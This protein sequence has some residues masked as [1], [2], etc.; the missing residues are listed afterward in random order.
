MTI[1]FAWQR[2]RCGALALT[3][4]LAALSPAFAATGVGVTGQGSYV[5]QPDPKH[6][7]M[8]LWKLWA[9]DFII[10]APDK[11][12]S[13]TLKG[14]HAILF[15]NGKQTADMVAPQAQSDNVKETI[16]A[17]GGVVVKSLTQPGTILRADNVVWNAASRKIIA[18]GHVFYKNGKT[19]MTIQPRG[20]LIADTVLKSVRSDDGGSIK[21]P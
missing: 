19:G 13:G 6:P 11:N 21:L 5:T 7:G 2:R 17:S 8:Y 18:S 16:V 9:R 12:V 10:E 15:Q 14:V 1:D 3:L 4:F 20:R